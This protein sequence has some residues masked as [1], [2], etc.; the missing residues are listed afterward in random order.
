MEICILSGTGGSLD[1]TKIVV[2][3]ATQYPSSK[4]TA[5]STFAPAVASAVGFTCA[6]DTAADAPA[7]SFDVRR[8]WKKLCNTS[9]LGCPPP[10]EV[11]F[12]GAVVPGLELELADDPSGGRPA[13]VVRLR[14]G[15]GAATA[16]PLVAPSIS[17]NARSTVGRE[18]ELLP[19]GPTTPAAASPGVRNAPRG[20]RSDFFAFS[21]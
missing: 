5:Q 18:N 1:P 20:S 15:T 12:G 19:S 13:V 7:R 2:Q 10:G 14:S 21:S 16:G 6:L 9:F 4:S 11:G 8:L 3:M 17:F